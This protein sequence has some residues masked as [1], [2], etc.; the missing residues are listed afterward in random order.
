MFSQKRPMSEQCRN[1]EVAKGED[2]W[3][4]VTENGLQGTTDI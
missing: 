2:V 3:E 1:N 4:R